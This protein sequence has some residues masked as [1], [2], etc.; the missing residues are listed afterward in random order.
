MEFASRAELKQNGRGITLMKR[1]SESKF[2]PGNGEGFFI[3]AMIW[4]NLRQ[5]N[6]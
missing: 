4:V 6:G 5:I 3:S 2:T 1:G